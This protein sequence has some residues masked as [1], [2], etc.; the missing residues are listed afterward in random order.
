MDF[1]L[2]RYKELLDAF[3][4]CGYSFQ[5]LEEFCLAPSPRAVIMRHD[6]DMLPLNALAIAT[7]EHELNVKASYHFRIVPVSFNQDIV[8]E[9][10]SLGHEAAYHYEDISIA[11]TKTG[12]GKENRSALYSGAYELFRENLEY[13]RK[14]YPVRVISMHGSPLSKYDNR[15]LWKYYDYRD[16]GIIC[17]PYFDIDF[18]DTL[19]LTDT[20]RRWDGDR[21]NLR[22]RAAAMSFSENSEGSFKVMPARGSAMNMTEESSAFQSCYRYKTTRDIIMAI[23]EG[24]LPDRV[25]VSTHPQRWSH[26]YMA[27]IRELVWQNTKNIIKYMLSHYRKTG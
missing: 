12:K 3:I 14:F 20:G 4:N 19:Y 18:S 15:I 5:T 24:S 8:K 16:D 11:A 13:L 26:Y 25:I 6:V 21:S 1:T 22:D 27:W 10:V 9:I 17:E 7:L 23:S 2:I